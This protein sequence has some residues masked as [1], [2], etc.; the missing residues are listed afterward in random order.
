[1]NAELRRWQCEGK[2]GYGS[3]ERQHG[4]KNRGAKKIESGAI[5]KG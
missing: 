5:E 1:M 2:T 4:K 3:A